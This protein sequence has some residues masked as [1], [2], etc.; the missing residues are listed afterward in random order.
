MT[1]IADKK[2]QDDEVILCV[3]YTSFTSWLVGIIS[4]FLGPVYYYG[5][6]VLL[7]QG[8]Y[9]AAAIVAFGGPV[10]FANGIEVLSSNCREG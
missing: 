2:P 6:H 10:L 1:D 5:A 4:I 8:D 7:Q 3:P 9:V